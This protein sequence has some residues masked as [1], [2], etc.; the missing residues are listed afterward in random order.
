MA[1]IG[2]LINVKFLNDRFRS[3]SVKLYSLDNYTEED[4]KKM[5]LNITKFYVLLYFSN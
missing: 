2:A 1:T 4:C 5:L 3:A